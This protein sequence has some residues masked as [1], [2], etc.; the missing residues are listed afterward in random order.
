MAGKLRSKWIDPFVVTNVFPHGA[1]EI[2]SPGTDKAFKI[3]GQHLKL[4]HES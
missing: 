3:N 2:K 4:F 1:V